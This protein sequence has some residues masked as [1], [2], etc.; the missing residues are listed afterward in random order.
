VVY[1]EGIV[2]EKMSL[3]TELGNLFPVRFYKDAAPTALGK[4]IAS[5]PGEGH[6]AKGFGKGGARWTRWGE[7]FLA[8]ESTQFHYLRFS[9]SWMSFES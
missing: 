1:G 2:G 3:L 8:A 7:G 6:G 9:E 4:R 5:R